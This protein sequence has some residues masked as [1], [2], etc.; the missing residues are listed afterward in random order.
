MF[1]RL[2]NATDWKYAGLVFKVG[3][4]MLV[5]RTICKATSFS[6]GTI[7]VHVADGP[8]P[9]FEGQAASADHIINQDEIIRI[10]YYNEVDPPLIQAPNGNKNGKLITSP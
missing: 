9:I 8:H 3:T 5:E 10:S 6:D 1:E 4:P 2:L 7:S